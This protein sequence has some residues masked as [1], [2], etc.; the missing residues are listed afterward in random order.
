VTERSTKS[1]ILV[2]GADGTIGSALVSALRTTNQ[3]VFE[4]TRR[5]DGEIHSSRFFLDLANP[6]AN[7]SLPANIAIAFILAAQTSTEYCRR[8]PR[9]SR[10]INV[11][12]TVSL[13]EALVKRGARVVFLSS[14]QVFDGTISSVAANHPQSP[15]TEYGRQKAEAEVRLLSLNGGVQIVRVTKVLSKK[16]NLLQ[17]WLTRLKAGEVIR[18]FSDMVLA[19]VSLSFLISV[20][21]NLIESSEGLDAQLG[22]IIQVSPGEDVTY[23]VMAEYLAAGFGI[24]QELIRPMK[25]AESSIQYEW[26][27][28][29]TTLDASDLERV[30]G[31]SVPD[32]RSCIN[33]LHLE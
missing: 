32:V 8:Y 22:S 30:F 16:T 25:V 33:Q 29:N 20:L 2:V 17:E 9:D 3:S 11:D 5:K 28:A 26:I 21:V 23:S 12:N 15:K 19:P 14:S 10:L 1:S 18:P 4:T 6:T 27:P 24:P 7:W 31:L 13:A